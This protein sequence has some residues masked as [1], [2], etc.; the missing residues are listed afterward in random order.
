MSTGDHG[1]KTGTLVEIN[2]GD[3]ARA[4]ADDWMKDWKIFLIFSTVFDKSGY[5]N[6]SL[7]T[8]AI[9]I[10]ISQTAASAIDT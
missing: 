1:A 5:R 3:T 7:C 9:P 2:G 6:L 8:L 10:P 4:G